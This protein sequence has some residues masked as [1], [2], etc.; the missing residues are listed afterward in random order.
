M[1]T[2]TSNNF[3]V[4]VAALAAPSVVDG[5]LH[6]AVAGG[7][8]EV[9]FGWT[10]PTT[11]SDA[12]FL[13]DLRS[14]KLYVGTATGVYDLVT[15][16]DTFTTGQK[17]ATEAVITGLTNA[18][19]YFFAVSAVDA[20][21]NEGIKSVEQLFV[22]AT[23]STP[24]RSYTDITS[25]T[26][27]STPGD[28]RLTAS[29]SGKITITADDVYLFGNGFTITFDT[30][31]GI[32]TS[33]TRDN[34]EIDAVTFSAVGGAGDNIRVSTTMTNS[35]IHHCVF[36]SRNPLTSGLQ[37][38][39]ETVNVSGLR[40]YLN[41]I[42]TNT[43]TTAGSGRSAMLVRNGSGMKSFGNTI[44][45][46]NSA[47]DGGYSDTRNCEIWG[48]TMI[49]SAPMGQG[50]YISHWKAPNV[51]I[52]D[53]VVDASTISTGRPIH[54]D[55]SL[56][57]TVLHNNIQVGAG[58]R[59]ISIRGASGLPSD[60][61]VAGF[62][63]I[64]G[65]NRGVAAGMKWGGVEGAT[66]PIDMYGYNN[67]IVGCG[68][69]SFEFYEQWTGQLSTWN[70]SLDGVGETVNTAPSLWDSN[71][72]TISG[73]VIGTASADT[74]NIF[75][76]FVVGQVS[77]QTSHINFVGS[78]TGFDGNADTPAAPTALVEIT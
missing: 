15:G 40:F 33:G 21:G 1:A 27:I 41:T 77:G 28:Y 22:A 71:N 5:L 64:D 9:H 53:N 52:H 31:H 48:D 46:Q 20:F 29:F 75:N 43:G 78:W 6:V 59:G 70:N 73:T 24:S 51:Y 37:V 49:F 17:G 47:R 18:V 7:S 58:Q 3:E 39:S 69:D 61:F 56:D 67:T 72:D 11:N 36:E 54:A 55:G 65:G 10:R 66:V 2:F 63:F 12:S 76:S 38:Q 13:G 60:R 42:D 45:C 23:P 14:F 35:K 44:N 34:I 19:T 68:S 57:W 30:D 74:W 4:T 8:A 25:T 62:N 26:T 50:T 32:A 16:L